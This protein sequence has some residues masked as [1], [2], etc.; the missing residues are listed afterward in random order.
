M[1]ERETLVASSETGVTFVRG[2]DFAILKHPDGGVKKIPE[3]F[4]DDLV[5]VSRGAARVD[6]F[7]PDFGAT[8]EQLRSE[9]YI[10]RGPTVEIHRPAFSVLPYACLTLLSLVPYVLVAIL[11]F[12]VLVTVV[13]SP[14]EQPP[15]WVLLYGPVVML[16][17]VAIHE[18]GH[19]REAGRYVPVSFGLGT[20]NGLV[21]AFKTYTTET[22]LLSRQHRMWV[23][24]SGI[25][26]QSIALLPLAGVYYLD[27][28]LPLPG[29]EASVPW[30]L[31]G[32]I[33]GTVTFVLN[34]VYHG[35]GYLVMTDLLGEHNIRKKAKRA[36]KERTVNLYA[37]YG[38]LSYGLVNV[39]MVVSSVITL[40]VW[41]WVVGSILVGLNVLFVV[42][43]ASESR[44]REFVSREPDWVRDLRDQV[45]YHAPEAGTP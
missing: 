44:A 32:Y 41:G 24:L 34:P 33:V 29:F 8:V 31:I 5:R 13:G 3:Q 20:I 17:T 45:R 25:T 39:Y 38:F 26:Y 35:D 40:L 37:V 15:L 30:L 27:V 9:G 6:E 10:Y 22:W 4:V 28:G 14:T 12:D 21:P 42:I 2:D 16:P 43:E 19:F 18:W 23:N 1:L 36:Y 11:E 7:P